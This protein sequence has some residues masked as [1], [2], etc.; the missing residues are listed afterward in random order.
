M[1]L[2][3]KFG[4]LTDERGMTLMELMVVVIIIGILTAIAVMSYGFSTNR[5]KET[6]CKAN[7]RTIR[8]A[9]EIYKSQNDSQ[10]P[11]DLDALVPDYIKDSNDVICP[12]TG[13]PYTYDS[14]TG[15]VSCPNCEP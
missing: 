11:P 1:D 9:L 8:S 5:A 4:S 14:A 6:A 2:A 12:A 3:R 7:L 10:Y 13:Q 15:T